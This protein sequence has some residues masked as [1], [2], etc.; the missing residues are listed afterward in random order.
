MAGRT[1]EFAWRHVRWS[2]DGYGIAVCLRV[3]FPGDLAGE[4]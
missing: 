3:N 2:A 4:T 1:I